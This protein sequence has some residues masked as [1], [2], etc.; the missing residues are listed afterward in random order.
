MRASWRLLLVI[1][2]LIALTQTSCTSSG[3]DSDSA[4]LSEPGDFDDNETASN[5]KDAPS[6]DDAEKQAEKDVAQEA[7]ENPPPIEEPAPPAI[8]ETPAPA[9]APVVEAPKPEP[10]PAPAP[11]A[12]KPVEHRSE[13]S[14]LENYL[15]G[16]NKFTG[17]KINIEA[18]DEDIKN[19]FKLIA[20]ES[21]AN[22]VLDEKVTGNVTV[23]LRQVPWDQAM[24]VVMKSKALGYVREGN[25]LRIAPLD[26][27]KK[28]SDMAH[29]LA[30]SREK[31]DP[32]KV[33]VIPVSYA[34]VDD[35]AKQAEKFLS[36]RGKVVSDN[37][38]S[39]LVITDT[40]E[41]TDRIVRLIKTLDVPP[42]Q[43]LIEGKI[44]EAQEQFR[45]NIG[46]K[47]SGGG[48]PTQISTNK[49]GL[50]VNVTPSLSVTPSTDAITG[51]N[52]DMKV[53]T[54]DVLGDLSAS[55]ALFESDN[56]VKVVS[57]PRIVAMNKE[58]AAINQV[59]QQPIETVTVSTTGAPTQ[60]SIRYEPAE[61]KLEVVPQIT[62]DG[63]VIMEME[64][65][66]EFFGAIEAGNRPKNT[67]QAKTKVIVRSGQTAVIGGI[68]DNQETVGEQGVPWLRK[69]P[70]IGW[71]FKYKST[72]KDKNELMIFLT[73]RILSR[74]ETTEVHR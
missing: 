13:E 68:F 34:N 27:L 70:L 16:Q 18:Q 66:R 59:L 17:R 61:L 48:S 22:L 54:L 43:V 39:S 10:T 37:R 11:V 5:D 6:A 55:L 71:L 14:Q 40:A 3:R 53:G 57:S 28:E 4:D 46:V 30:D 15:N 74:S 19:V 26:Q 42:D 52:F 56:L 58:R 31:M 44:V 41:T 35:L 25:V 63:S 1:P 20:E 9:P 2:L 36:A 65:K 49:L 45:R 21:G 69:L 12:A 29:D 64:V 60:K 50:P 32:L 47:W 67:R 51:L 38:T 23:K 73:P 62:A 72:T 24:T 7:Q 33:K 8:T